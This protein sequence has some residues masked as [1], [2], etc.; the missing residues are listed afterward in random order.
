VSS[1]RDFGSVR[2]LASGR[3]QA[4]AWSEPRGRQVSIGTFGTKTEAQ[5]ALAST[6][7]DQARGAWIDP[8]AGRLTLGEYAPRWLDHRPDLRPRTREL[9]ASLL[10][11]H[12]LPPLGALPLTK[13]STAGVREWHA[14]LSSP[15]GPGASTAAKAYRLLRTIL[16]TAFEDGLIAA[17]PCTIRRAGQE[18]SAKRPLVAI[19]DV[20]ALAD[21]IGPELRALVLLAAFGGLRRGELLALRRRNVDPLHG[22][23]TI[24]EQ[25]QRLQYGRVVYAPPKTAAGLRTVTLPK[26]VLDEL[27]SHLATGADG[28]DALVFNGQKGGPLSEHMLQVRWNRARRTVGLPDVHLHDLRH[29]A[30]TLAASTGASTAELMARLG[31]SSPAAALRYQHATRDRDEAIAAMMGDAIERS[32]VSSPSADIVDI[33]TGRRFV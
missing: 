7:A 28:P 31:H 12:V 2:K 14:R 3:W 15:A 29:H 13:I 24:I 6:T 25:V 21:A 23:V 30:G 16:G 33:A 19:G 17:N 32:R 18:R 26:P 22:T 1:R 9:Y 4:R 8:G 5:K 27:A 20:Y 10:R 11:L